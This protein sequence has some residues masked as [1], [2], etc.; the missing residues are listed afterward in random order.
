MSD[1]IGKTYASKEALE[2]DVQFYALKHGFVVTTLHL[3]GDKDSGYLNCVHRG[4]PRNDGEERQRNTKTMACDCKWQVYARLPKKAQNG[5]SMPLWEIR[6]VQMNSGAIYSYKPK[7]TRLIEGSE[8]SHSLISSDDPKDV[9]RCYMQHR[10]LSEDVKSTLDAICGTVSTDV[11]ISMVE[12][13]HPDAVITRRAVHNATQQQKGVPGASTDFE[14]LKIYLE[15]AGYLVFYDT[16][17]TTN[18]LKSL[19]VVHADA[20]PDARRFLK[21]VLVD[22][23]YKTNFHKM[24][25]VHIVGVSNLGGHQNL[26]SFVIG[27]ALL[28]NEKKSA[29]TWLATM[30]RKVVWPVSSYDGPLL[31]VT[32]EDDQLVSALVEAFPNSDTML[33]AW[34][35]YNNFEKQYRGTFS[36]KVP[37]QKQSDE[38]IMGAIVKELIWTRDFASFEKAESKFREHA[39]NSGACGKLL[40]YLNKYVISLFRRSN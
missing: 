28:S 11:A 19:F 14:P 33:C 13:E 18:I 22:A 3:N 10:K 26:H 24:P 7:Q 2:Q 35:I 1:F 27:Y 36:K 6:K 37:G 20:I 15:S 5:G 9:A 23:T 12:N 34:H 39:K 38:D 30:L 8:H 21:V 17:S 16:T 32:D 29:Y 4:K 40:E 31:F 25:L